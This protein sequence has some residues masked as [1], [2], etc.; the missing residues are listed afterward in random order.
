MISSKYI[1]I[2]R[3]KNINY[4]LIVWIG[5]QEIFH[6]FHR[7]YQRMQTVYMAQFFTLSSNDHHRSNFSIPYDL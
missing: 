2:K 1:C 3:K 5:M 4:F 6:Q 7:P